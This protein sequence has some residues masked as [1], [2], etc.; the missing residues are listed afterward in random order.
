MVGKERKWDSRKGTGDGRG[1][2]EHVEE[3]NGYGLLDMGG[4]VWNGV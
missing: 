4:M 1:G 3:E 2:Y